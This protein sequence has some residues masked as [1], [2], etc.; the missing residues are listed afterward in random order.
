MK[1]NLPN[2]AEGDPAEKAEEHI[3]TLEDQAEMDKKVEQEH[4]TGGSIN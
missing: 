2:S 3:R 1:P 4:S